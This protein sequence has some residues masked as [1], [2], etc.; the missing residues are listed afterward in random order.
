MVVVFILKYVE[1]SPFIEGVYR[2]IKFG[3]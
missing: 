3:F 1:L 2:I